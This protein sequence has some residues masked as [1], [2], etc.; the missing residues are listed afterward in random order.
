VTQSQYL[1]IV[2]RD[3]TLS[4]SFIKRKISYSISKLLKQVTRS[5]RTNFRA[6]QTDRQRQADRRTKC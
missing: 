2:F 1:S 3:R 5:I 6:Q 4:G